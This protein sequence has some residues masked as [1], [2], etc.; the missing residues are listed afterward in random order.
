MHHRGSMFGETLKA[1]PAFTEQ[2][3]NRIE[4]Q[5]LSSLARRTFH[6]CIQTVQFLVTDESPIVVRHSSRTH[7]TFHHERTQIRTSLKNAARAFLGRIHM[8]DAFS[9]QMGFTESNII[10]DLSVDDPSPAHTALRWAGIP[11]PLS[12]IHDRDFCG[13]EC[14]DFF[15]DD[16]LSGRKGWAY[17]LVSVD[18]IACPP[19]A[20][21]VRGWIRLAHVFLDTDV[22]NLID[23]IS[24]VHVDLSGPTPQFL[25]RQVAKQILRDAHKN[26]QESLVAPPPRRRYSTSS[27]STES[28]RSWPKAVSPDVLDRVADTL[29]DRQYYSRRPTSS[30]SAAY[31]PLVSPMACCLTCRAAAATEP[32]IACKVCD[33]TSCLPCGVRWRVV[34]KFDVRIHLCPRCYDGLIQHQGQSGG[35]ASQHESKQSH[36]AAA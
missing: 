33:T 22:A 14:G 5:Y 3:M 19:Q 8:D 34:L 17:S 1:R 6:D 36:A 10:H 11:S 9:A 12:F 27:I 7:A 24:F 16:A 32:L 13:V 23:V 4:T 29:I 18:H 35:G 26:L 28:L 30:S 15:R 2:G 31:P 20:N 25:A 21:Y